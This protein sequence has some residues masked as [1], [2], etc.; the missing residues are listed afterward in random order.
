MQ[1]SKTHASPGR[2]WATGWA[3]AVLVSVNR[4]G[5]GRRLYRAIEWPSE[6]CSML[7]SALPAPSWEQV[8]A[9][10]WGCSGGSCIH[11]CPGW[12]D[13]EAL[14]RE[15]ALFHL[16]TNMGRVTTRWLAGPKDGEV[17][18]GSRKYQWSCLRSGLGKATSMGA[19]Q[20]SQLSSPSSHLCNRFQPYRLCPPYSHLLPI[21]SH[22]QEGPGQ[23]AGV[24]C[25]FCPKLCL[26]N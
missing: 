16:L 24:Q 23:P 4:A 6:M 1:A 7:M 11:G 5:L 21:P 15:R 10:C 17:Y 25:V 3:K 2:N 19:V 13:G 18:V 12:V 26:I 22:Q 9:S 20:V 8:P 14:G